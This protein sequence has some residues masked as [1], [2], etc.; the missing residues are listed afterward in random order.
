MPNYRSRK[1]T[2]RG[3]TP[4]ERRAQ[5]AGLRQRLEEWEATTPPE[6]IAAAIAR[7]SRYSER[8][9]KLIAMQRPDATQVAMFKSWL[10]FGR[11]VRKGERGIMIIVPCGMTSE[12]G[13]GDGESITTEGEAR[14][15][16]AGDA[17]EGRQRF[18]VGYVFDVS[19]TSEQDEEAAS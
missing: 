14:E 11:C 5:V 7:F 2:R 10:G 9:A 12:D 8:N 16:G 1:S 13:A 18:K 19:Q 17:P 15:D 4:E 3:K 6:V